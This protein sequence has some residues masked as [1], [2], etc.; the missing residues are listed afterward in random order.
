MQQT[1]RAGAVRTALVALALLAAPAAS[2]ADHPL[3]ATVLG[4]CQPDHSRPTEVAAAAKRSGWTEAMTLGAGGATLMKDI[5]GGSQMLILS[6]KPITLAD[7]APA[8]FNAC[9]ASGDVSGGDLLASV[10]ALMGH[11]PQVASGPRA[12]TWLFTERDGQR[13]FLP[14]GSMAAVAAA[15]KRGPVVIVRVPPSG[16]YVEY[17]EISAGATAP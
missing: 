14:D 13:R 9:Q 7:G 11:D 2:A 6:A 12:T 17:N 5:D 15:V 16:R 3:L 1:A 10:R 8:V 4:L